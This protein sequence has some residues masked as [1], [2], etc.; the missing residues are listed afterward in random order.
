METLKF[1]VFGCRVLVASSSNGW[2]TFCLGNKDRRSS[3][4]DIAIPPEILKSEIAQYLGDFSPD[5]PT[6]RHHGVK[7]LD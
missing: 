7:Q 4:P 6:E 3:A 1:D 5:G 2:V